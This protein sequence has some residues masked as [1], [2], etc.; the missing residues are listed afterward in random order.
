MFLLFDRSEILIGH[1]KD[2]L[3]ARHTEEINGE[4]ILEITILDTVEKGQRIAYKDSLG[5][6]HE[7]IVKGVEEAHDGDMVTRTVFAESSFYEMLGDYIEDKRPTNVPANIALENALITT[8]WEVGIVDDLGLNSTNFYH[9]S[10]KEAVQKVAVVWKGEIRTRVEVSGNRITG[11]YVDLLERRGE[12]RGK[13]F[14]YTKDLESITKIL[15]RDDVI[16]ALYGYGKGE[17][18][19][20]GGYGRRITFADINDGKAYVENLEAKEIWGRPNNDGTKSHVFSKVEF[21]DC[22]DPA[23]LLQLTT[24]KLEELSEPLISYQATVVDLKAFGIEHEGVDL[25]DTVAI[26]DREFKPELRLKARVVKITRDL[27]EP[28]NT[29]IVLGNFIPSIVDQWTEQEQHINNF[30]EKQGIWDRS[31]IIEPDG[32][33]NAQYLNNLVAALNAKMNALGGYVYISDQGDGLITYDKPDPEEATMAIQILG[34]SFRIANSKGPDG[35]WQ[36]RTFGDGNGFIADAFIGGVLKGGKVHF[37]LTNGTLR[38][39]DSIDDYTFLWDG[40]SLWLNGQI[41]FTDNGQL[42][43][44]IN[45]QQL[46]IRSAVIT[47]SMVLGNHLIEKHANGTSF[48]WAGED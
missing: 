46:Y 31:Q 42:V 39:G 11:R 27:L 32:T 12:D 47:D 45:G 3:T 15:H 36:W 7:F 40:S 9:I 37:D 29:V 24:A 8:R 4:N 33:I 16:T 19:D 43:A 6:W 13:R 5:H 1:L 48:K 44:W 23:E 14:T 22:E 26:I 30:R 41:N 10:A 21:D 18:L 35:G 38:I 34:G 2:V 17:L 20:T 25:G 28:E